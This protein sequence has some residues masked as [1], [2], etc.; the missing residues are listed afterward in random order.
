MLFPAQPAQSVHT[1]T[2]NG[3]DELVA[4]IT[5]VFF[6]G[7]SCSFSLGKSW[8]EGLEEHLLPSNQEGKLLTQGLDS[9]LSLKVK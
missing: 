5:G 6:C 9:Q 1:G 8:E 3:T 2:H 4:F 7:T